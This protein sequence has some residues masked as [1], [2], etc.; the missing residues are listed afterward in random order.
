MSDYTTNFPSLIT[1]PN[2]R[3]KYT[4]RTLTTEATFNLDFG[5]IPHCNSPNRIVGLQLGYP[6][7]GGVNDM[8]PTSMLN[9]AMGW[10]TLAMGEWDAYTGA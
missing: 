8:S 3:G 10:G 6:L 1:H 7:E 2:V 4:A 5:F 9:A